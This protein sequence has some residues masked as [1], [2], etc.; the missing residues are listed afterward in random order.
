MDIFKFVPLNFPVR[1]NSLTV[2][3]QQRKLNFFVKIR[4]KSNIWGNKKIFLFF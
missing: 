3:T 2:T 4:K 1:E